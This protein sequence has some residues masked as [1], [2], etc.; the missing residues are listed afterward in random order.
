VDGVL[1]GH[2]HSAA[3]RK[4]G[5]VTYYNCGDWVETCSALIEH[6]DG[7]IEIVPQFGVNRIVMHARASAIAETV[8]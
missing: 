8:A 4:F 7:Q 3:I 5:N 1:C 2:I 6:F